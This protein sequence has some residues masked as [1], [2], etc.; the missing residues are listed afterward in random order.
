M[1]ECYNVTGGPEDEDDPRN[2][3]IPKSEDSQDITSPEISKKKTN[4]PLKI[5]KVNIGIEENPKFSNIG[6]YWDEETMAKVTDFLHEFQKLYPTKFSKI[7]GI[8]GDLGEM[9][10]PLNLDVK[11]VKKCLYHLNL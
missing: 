3:N 7:K 5:Q 9:K 4:H 10:I 2:V 6:D 11:Y 8:L 1:V